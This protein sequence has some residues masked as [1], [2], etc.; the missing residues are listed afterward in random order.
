MRKCSA[1]LPRKMRRVMPLE[2]TIFIKISTSFYHFWNFS[3]NFAQTWNL[4]RSIQ[5][6]QKILNFH[7]QSIYAPLFVVEFLVGWLAQS[8]GLIADSL[9][10][11]ADATI[12]GVALYAVGHS[13]KRK[14]QNRWLTRSARRWSM[15]RQWWTTFSEILKIAK[16]WKL[17]WRSTRDTSV[18]PSTS[19][20]VACQALHQPV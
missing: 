15:L 8:A 18:N 13:V 1:Q 4:A 5:N 10:M 7:I 19:S 16:L 6:T 17:F 12:Y 11:F 20:F 3:R 2:G 14:L 9:D